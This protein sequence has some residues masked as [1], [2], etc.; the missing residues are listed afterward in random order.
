MTSRM[1]ADEYAS[2]S[3]WSASFHV[4]KCSTSSIYLKWSSE[5]WTT[6]F[7][8][9]CQLSHRR[10]YSFRNGN[11][12]FL[13]FFIQCEKMLRIFFFFLVLSTCNV[14]GTFEL[15]WKKYFYRKANVI[16]RIF[17]YD[18][19]IKLVVQLLSVKH[20]KHLLSAWNKSW[21]NISIER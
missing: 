13:Y 15:S 12:M 8:C 11:V 5:I 16:S 20:L 17:L 21:S 6:F 10:S 14:Y 19:K 3:K 18:A 9:C 2:N 4:V 7:F 1:F